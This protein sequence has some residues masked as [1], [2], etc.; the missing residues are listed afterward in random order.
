MTAVSIGGMGVTS[1]GVLAGGK[2]GYTLTKDTLSTLAYGAVDIV[3]A[4]QADPGSVWQKRGACWFTIGIFT[5]S[6]NSAAYIS[7]DAK[8]TGTIW[9]T[10]RL[11]FLFA[12]NFICKA[13]L[14]GGVMMRAHKD[15]RPNVM[16]WF[17]LMCC[18]EFLAFGGSATPY[19][20]ITA[21][22]NVLVLLLAIF[23]GYFLVMK[24]DKGAEQ[25]DVQNGYK[26]LFGFAMSTIQWFNLYITSLT[27]LGPFVISAALMLFQ[28]MV[29]KVIIPALKLCFGDDHRKMW[30]YAVPAVV[31]GL[32]LGPCLLLLGSDK[33]AQP[34][35][36]EKN[37]ASR[38][39]QTPCTR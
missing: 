18:F 25:T 30:S 34:R 13:G 4:Q 8:R 39:G 28:K 36:S 19:P 38:A 26:L 20:L 29:L 14:V 3:V 1:F 17:V 11:L 12:W 24:I 33:A 16:K 5:G 32:E 31:L 21:L 2:V 23:G 35:S 37:A 9:Q 27:F 6:V 10:E 15:R 7:F 22:G